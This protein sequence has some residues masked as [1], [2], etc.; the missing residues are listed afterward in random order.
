[1]SWD[2]TAMLQEMEL[3]KGMVLNNVRLLASHNRKDPYYA[4]LLR[5]ADQPYFFETYQV[6]VWAGLRLQPKRILEIG[7]RNG[8][9]LV[10][11]LSAYHRF[12]GISVVCCDL[13]R[14]IGSPRAVRANLK[15]MAIPDSLVEF[16]SGDSTQ[17]VPAWRRQH[18]QAQFDYVLVDGGH[19]VPTAGRDLANVADLVAPGGILIF[20]DIGPESYR[21][22]PVWREFQ[23]QHAGEFEWFEKQWRKGV[24][25]AIRSAAAGGGA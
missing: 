3:L 18:P 24:A 1:M 13:W 16:V 8:G 21:L 12:D 25:W 2:R 20:D 10:Q 19:D 11:L 4:E 6:I 14:E 23:A 9:S 15:L 7:T 22:L 5:L 17:T